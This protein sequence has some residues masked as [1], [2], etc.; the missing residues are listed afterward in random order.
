M[1]KEDNNNKEWSWTRNEKPVLYAE[2]NANKC[3]YAIKDCEACFRNRT[4]YCME[5]RVQPAFFIGF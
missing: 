5:K 4:C 2:S 3:P 1:G